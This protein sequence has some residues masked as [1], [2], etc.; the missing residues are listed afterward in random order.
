MPS[1]APFK[2]ARKWNCA[3][4][5][6]TKIGAIFVCHAI[7]P[8]IAIRHPRPIAAGCFSQQ[9]S[10]QQNKNGTVQAFA[11]AQKVFVKLVAAY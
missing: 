6:A 1:I 2:V 9:L 5:R 8:E 4:L 10:R 7:S 11:L 3:N